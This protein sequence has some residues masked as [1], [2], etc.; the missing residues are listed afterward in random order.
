[1][2]ARGQV[3]RDPAEDGANASG[4]AIGLASSSAGG[5]PTLLDAAAMALG[6][7]GMDLR[8]GRRHPRQHVERMAQRLAH[9]LQPTERTSPV[10]S[11]QLDS[12]QKHIRRLVL[13]SVCLQAILWRTRFVS[14]IGAESEPR[15]MVTTQQE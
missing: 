9:A 7:L 13:A 11:N 5:Q 6:P 1:M 8:S 2:I 3:A 4:L 15:H 12:E 10:E 14:R